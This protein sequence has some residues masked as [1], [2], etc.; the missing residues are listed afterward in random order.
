MGYTVSRQNFPEFEGCLNGCFRKILNNI[1]VSHKATTHAAIMIQESKFVCQC[2]KF[3]IG[4]KRRLK[5]QIHCQKLK[6]SPVL[7]PALLYIICENFMRITFILI[8]L[9]LLAMRT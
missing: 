4:Q 3:L 7:M 1:Y 5:P 2:R 6:R 9:Y 8:I